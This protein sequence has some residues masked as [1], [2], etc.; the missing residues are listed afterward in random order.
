MTILE[1]S[2]RTATQPPRQAIIIII[3]HIV[4][5]IDILP[6]TSEGLLHYEKTIVL[7]RILFCRGF[8]SK[9][10]MQNGGILTYKNKVK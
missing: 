6:R 9:S 3:S 5:I 1:R 2:D 8:P 4:S 7:A 10:T